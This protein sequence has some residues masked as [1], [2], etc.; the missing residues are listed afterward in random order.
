[1]GWMEIGHTLIDLLFPPRCLLCHQPPQVTRDCFCE[2]C[3]AALFNDSKRTCPRCAATVGLHATHDGRCGLCRGESF[4][5]TGAVR[6]GAYEGVIQ[7]AVL[8]MKHASQEGLA[9]V[10]GERWAERQREQLLASAP[11]VIIPVPLHWRKRLWRGYNQSAALAGAM[12]RRLGVMCRP[13]WLRKVRPTSEQKALSSFQARQDNV[14]GAFVGDRAVAG[15]RVLLVDD[16][17]TTGAT[18]S[19]AAR[20]LVKIGAAVVHVAI[21]ARASG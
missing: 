1:M 19:E 13:G 7:Q 18:A 11:Q 4:G 21:V 17:M 14:K 8:R 5:F 9:E 6:L 3:A 16:V 20:T 15:L 10:I 2:N 12:S